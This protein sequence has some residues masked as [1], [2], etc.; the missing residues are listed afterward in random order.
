[1]SEKF[2]KD[3][4]V[5][6]EMLQNEEKKISAEEVIDKALAKDLSDKID[7]HVPLTPSVHVPAKTPVKAEEKVEHNTSDGKAPRFV[8]GS[9]NPVNEK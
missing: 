1:M 7:A 8:A 9:L 3:E 6:Q 5:E 4:Q 2:T